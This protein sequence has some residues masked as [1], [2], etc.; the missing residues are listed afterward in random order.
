MDALGGDPSTVSF[1]D[2][3]ARHA[4]AFRTWLGDGFAALSD[5]GAALA[6]ACVVASRLKP[7]GPAPPT[8][9]DLDSLLRAPSLTCDQYVALALRLFGTLRGPGPIRVSA[10]GWRSDSAVGNHAQLAAWDGGLALVLDPTVG[11]VGAMSASH[12]LPAAAPAAAHVAALDARGVTAPLRESVL[13]VLGGHA[14]LRARDLIFAFPA[15]APDQISVGAA[16]FVARVADAGG[17]AVCLTGAGELRRPDGTSLA[18]DRPVWSAVAAD[19]ERGTHHAL[20]GDGVLWAVAPDGLRRFRTGVSALVESAGARRAWILSGGAIERTDGSATMRAPRCV[21]L[22]GGVGGHAVICVDTAG[23]AWGVRSRGPR[24]LLA[25]GVTDVVDGRGG[26]QGRAVHLVCASGDVLRACRG[27][28]G[29]VSL[30]RTWSARGG[31]IAAR[32][33]R[34]GLDGRWLALLLE[35]GTVVQGHRA[36]AGVSWQPPWPD[37]P[38]E[39]LDLAGDGLTLVG[40]RRDGSVRAAAASPTF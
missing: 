10:V 38:Y 18:A 21:A 4:G 6:F 32:S 15:L 22:A 40:R 24:R 12:E 29:R 3:L 8:D 35:D 19:R 14:S 30:E 5:N 23:R 28:L 2:L 39:A 11:V 27:R 34:L 25:R 16:D 1:P 7:W 17:H 36:D 13:R 37:G 20:A 31:R 9:W 33:L 26:E